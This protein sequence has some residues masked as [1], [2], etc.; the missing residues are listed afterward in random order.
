MLETV[1]MVELVIKLTKILGLLQVIFGKGNLQNRTKIYIFY[2]W[3]STL[4]LMIQM[5]KTTTFRVL[6][7]VDNF[8]WI[9]VF[10]V[11]VCF[12]NLRQILI[13]VKIKFA[14]KMSALDLT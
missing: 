4:P 13:F 14:D 1:F 5:I 8:S 2:T 12:L 10:K 6:I 3:R 9:L 11:E 7:N